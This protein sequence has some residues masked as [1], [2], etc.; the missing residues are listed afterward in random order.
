MIVEVRVREEV[1]LPPGGE[2][3]MRIHSACL[4]TIGCGEQAWG[5]DW[6]YEVHPINP[7]WLVAFSAEW[8]P[9]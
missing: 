6:L 2:D 8:V 5:R 7:M 9:L 1:F 3:D 4:W